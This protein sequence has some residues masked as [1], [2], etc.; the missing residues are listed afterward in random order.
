MSSQWMQSICCAVEQLHLKGWCSRLWC[1][2]TVTVHVLLCSAL[3]SQLSTSDEPCAAIAASED[4]GAT[5]ADDWP[6]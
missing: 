6:L 1:A 3:P 5:G 4:T 2:V